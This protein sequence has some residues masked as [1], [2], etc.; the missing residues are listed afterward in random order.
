MIPITPRESRKLTP[1][2]GQFT[3]TIQVGQDEGGAWHYRL[4]MVGE[5]I[6]TAGGWHGPHPDK[7]TAYIAGLVGF[8]LAIS[9]LD[10]PASKP[11][12]MALDPIL[13]AFGAT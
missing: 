10:G 7:E 2:R 11:F 9:Y 1:R 8:N 3:P 13:D 4:L 5:T 12:K 6:I